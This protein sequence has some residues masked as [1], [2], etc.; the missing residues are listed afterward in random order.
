MQWAEANRQTEMYCAEAIAE[1]QTERSAR[2]SDPSGVGGDAGIHRGVGDERAR[3]VGN[4][5]ISP[6]GGAG[7]R[8]GC[9]VQSDAKSE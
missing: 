1:W 6:A 2:S 9:V 3:G 8:R 5:D 4:A 7:S